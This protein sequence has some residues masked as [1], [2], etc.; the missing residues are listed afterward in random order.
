MG[1]PPKYATVKEAAQ[2]NLYSKLGGQDGTGLGFGEFALVS[3][4]RCYIC[5]MP[6]SEKLIQKRQGE[7]FILE[8]NY[9]I[10]KEPT[11]GMCKRLAKD[12]GIDEIVSH[13]GKIM[14]KRMHD[15]RKKAH[16]EAAISDALDTW[17]DIVSPGPGITLTGR[18]PEDT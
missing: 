6:P 3:H 2:Q 10:D 12:Y 7:E 9:V 17:A 4:A 14:A 15:K 5:H 18:S 1:R 16:A 13:A 8:W 11:C